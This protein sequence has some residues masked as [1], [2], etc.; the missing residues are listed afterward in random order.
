LWN[1]V[2]R[3]FESFLREI[4]LKATDRADAEA[5]ALRVARSLFAE[6]YPD[7]EFNPNCYSIVGSYAKGTAATPRTDVDM[8]FVLP[9]REFTRINAVSNNKQSYLLQEVKD[10]LLGTYPNT[11]IRGDG[12]VVKVP[13]STYEFEVCPVFKLQD[14]SFI[15]AHT[16]NGGRWGNT[17]PALELQWIRNVDA[18]TLG[19]ATDLAKML[20]AWKRGCSVDT[21]SIC[22]EVAAVYFVERWFYRNQTIFWYDWMV[23]DFF[24]FLLNYRIQGWA[25]PAGIAE[26]IFFGDNWQSKCRTAYERAVKACQYE[27][28]DQGYLASAEWQKIFG[29]QFT[30]DLIEFLPPPALGINFLRL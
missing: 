23:R 3:H 9:D 28:A 19:K 29:S 26:Q 16:K 1:H 7:Q 8:I 14:N 30:S 12:P 10:A 6:Y 15:N 27:Y 5:K 11:D 21:K 25:K 18:A 22:L 17:H 20:K 2:I 24:A 13:F 4:N